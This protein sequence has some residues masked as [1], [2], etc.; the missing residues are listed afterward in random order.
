[1]TKGIP[2]AT[3]GL[4]MFLGLAAQAQLP[5]PIMYFP[6][7]SVDAGGGDFSGSGNSGDLLNGAVI[8]DGGTGHTG[9]ADDR[10]LDLGAF[11]NGAYVNVPSAAT[12]G[13]GSLVENDAATLSFWTFGG[14]EQPVSQWAFRAQGPGNDRVLGSHTPW[15]DGTFYFDVAG[16]CGATQRISAAAPSESDYKGQWN[17]YALLKDGSMTAVYIN[18]ELLVDSGVNE[19]LPLTEITE[20]VVGASFGGGGSYAGMFDDFALFDVALTPDQIAGIVGGEP[21]PGISL[22]GDFDESGAI[23]EGDFQILA[24]N[25]GAHLVSDVRHSDGDFDLNG[26]VNLHDFRAFKGAFPGVVAAATGVPEPTSVVLVVLATG[27]LLPL[28]RRRPKR[29]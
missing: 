11:N 17:H 28:V 21:I 23:D 10:A 19:M 22:Q 24:M 4:V 1:M 27:A 13:L 29:N 5:D 8:S 15:S 9:E 6:F 14:E 18:G 20:L 3:L 25:L 16:C 12:G 26:S 2:F 7:D